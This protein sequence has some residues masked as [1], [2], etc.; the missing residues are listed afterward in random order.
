MLK[1]FIK[2]FKLLTQIFGIDCVE[3]DNFKLTVF[4]TYYIFIFYIF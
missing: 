2:Y 3:F 4:N 1:N